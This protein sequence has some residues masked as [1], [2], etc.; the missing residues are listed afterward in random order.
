MQKQAGDMF[1]T[2]SVLKAVSSKYILRRLKGKIK[3]FFQIMSFVASTLVSTCIFRGQLCVVSA[4]S[5][6]TVQQL[7]AV[8]WKQRT[9]T[10]HIS[11]VELHKLEN[12]PSCWF[13]VEEMEFHCKAMPVEVLGQETALPAQCLTDA[14][15]VAGEELR[16]LQHVRFKRIF[17]ERFVCIRVSGRM[18]WPLGAAAASR[19]E[20]VGVEGAE[21]R[22]GL[23][24][25][26]VYPVVALNSEIIYVGYL[27]I[28]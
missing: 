19:E 20:E 25:H 13:S 6:A 26:G 21:E 5:A 3:F 7:K 12:L 9:S 11:Q 18:H 15:Y 28:K 8:T 27:F 24:V 4:A 2:Q 23:S 1:K 22:K 14:N 10:E 16:A 17:T